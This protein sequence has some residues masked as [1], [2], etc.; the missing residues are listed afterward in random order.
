M[1]EEHL[2]D[3][4]LQ[5]QLDIRHRV[6]SDRRLYAETIVYSI[7]VFFVVFGYYLVLT[8]EVTVRVINRIIAD[9]SFI[10][11]GFSLMLSS[12]CYF[13]DFADKFIIY[14]KHLGLVGFGYMIIHV[15]ISLFYSGYFPLISYYLSDSRIMSFTTAALA[16]VIFFI[17]ALISNR[18]SIQKIGPKRWKALMRIGYIGYALALFH[19]AQKGLPA[20]GFWFTGKGALFPAFSLL[21]F[22]MGVVI[23]VMRIALWIKTRQKTGTPQN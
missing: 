20:W 2:M 12:V 4:K 17:M 10:M 13:W 9:L 11:I 6:P 1:V 19:F 16:T 21:V 3:K 14:R 18:T 7:I 5:Q 23:L 8:P 15:A 22:L